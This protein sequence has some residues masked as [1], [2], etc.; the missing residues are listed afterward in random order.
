MLMKHFAGLMYSCRYIMLDIQCMSITIDIEQM[1][2]RSET[3][4]RA[5]S[6]REKMQETEEE[7][8]VSTS[9]ILFFLSYDLTTIGL[10]YFS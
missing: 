5:Y 1:K 10:L 4:R 6:A 9:L 3:N 8:K 2:R 7:E